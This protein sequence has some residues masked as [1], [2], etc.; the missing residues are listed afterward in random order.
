MILQRV[1]ITLF[2]TVMQK[3]VPQVLAPSLTSHSAR[4][5]LWASWPGYVARVAYPVGNTVA[6]GTGR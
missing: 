3:S 5:S 4:R 2:S 1:D 6:G